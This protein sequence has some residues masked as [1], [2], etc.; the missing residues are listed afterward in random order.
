MLEDISFVAEPGQTV[1]L[2]GATGSGKTT[3]VAL[4]QKFYLPVRGAVLV[5][6]HD[7][8]HVTS[9]SILKQMGNVQQNNFLFSGSIIDNI[10]FARP[11]ATETECGPPFPT[12]TAW[13]Y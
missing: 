6:G 1:A 2:V 4:L 11:D 13:T 10:R 12:S 9:E 3:L 5:D 8:Q 7:L